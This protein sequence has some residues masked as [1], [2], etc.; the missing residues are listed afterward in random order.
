MSSP[1]AFGFE[2]KQSINFLFQELFCKRPF[3]YNYV[4]RSVVVV[5]GGGGAWIWALKVHVNFF[6]SFNEAMGG[7][8]MPLAPPVSTTDYRPSNST[9]FF[10]FLFTYLC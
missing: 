1:G 2:L 5:G 10:F 8:G 6:W 7:E 9:I 4:V 3:L